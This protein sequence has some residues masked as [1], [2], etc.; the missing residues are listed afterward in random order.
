[1]AH[2]GYS[3]DATGGF[4]R[5]VGCCRMVNELGARDYR[6]LAM[7]GRASSACDAAG[8]GA[9]LVRRLPTWAGV[10][11]LSGLPARLLL[12]YVIWQAWRLDDTAAAAGDALRSL[13]YIA[14]GAW[15]IAQIGRQFFVRA[16]AMDL[17]G[18]RLRASEVLRVPRSTIIAALWLAIALEVLF[19]L[20]MPMIIPSLVILLLV[21]VGTACAAEAG[22]GWS[23]PIRCLYQVVRP[24][25]LI[26]LG[27]GFLIALPLAMLNLHFIV[28]LLLWLIE[29]LKDFARKLRRECGYLKHVVGRRF[30]LEF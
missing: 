2:G 18:G 11:L 29:G 21:P 25:P 27:V 19:W 28:R 22:P 16:S 6:R 5:A 1:M 20:T 26:I 17:D 14:L 10:L 12:A 13:A 23:A 4:D 8:R 3:A 7:S 9:E 24:L 30:F 15:V